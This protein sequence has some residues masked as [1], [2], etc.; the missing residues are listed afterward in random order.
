MIIE[1]RQILKFFPPILDGGEKSEKLRYMLV[2]NNNETTNE[3]SMLNVSSIKRNSADLLRDSNIQIKEY[4]PLPVPS[5]IKLGTTYKIPYFR[6]LENFVISFG[7]KIRD[8]QFDK[9]MEEYKKY[10][11]KKQTNNEII[12]SEEKFKIYN[13]I[14]I[15]RGFK[16]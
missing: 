7:G 10:N 11:N 14:P 9:I 16:V 2:I 6:E 3:I 5:Y 4:R 13:K 15:Q 12:F 1:E 8:T